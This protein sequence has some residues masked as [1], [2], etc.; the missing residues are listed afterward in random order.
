MDKYD[1][2]TNSIGKIITNLQSFEFVLRL[3]LYEIKENSQDQSN[4][5]FEITKLKI[6][7]S[8]EE[9]HLTNFDSLK[10]LI[11]KVNEELSSRNIPE[12]IDESLANLRDV[13]A[14]GRV[15]ALNPVGPYNIIKFS[16]PIGGNVSVI[17][18]AELTEKWLFDQI[19]RIYGE[20]KK[21]IKI[22][23]SIGLNIFPDD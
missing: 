15:L 7:D 18:S 20:I 1:A 12:Q 19:N 21:I 6:G 8:L 13:I 5:P 4:L 14:H 2:V 11:R 9:N 16:K 17:F 22:S 10:V 23:R 3:F